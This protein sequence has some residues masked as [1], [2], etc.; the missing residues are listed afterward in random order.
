MT[1]EPT[2]SLQVQNPGLPVPPGVHLNCYGPFLAPAGAKSLRT[3]VPQ[4]DMSIVH[5][6]IMFGGRGAGVSQHTKPGQ[7]HLCFQGSIV[8]AWARTGQTTPLGLDFKD[9]PVQG[10]GFEVGPGTKYEW[11][12]LQIHYQ[13]LHSATKYDSSG[14]KLGFST[15]PP[16]RPLEVQLM[17]SWRLRIPPRSK[18]DECVACRV[19][20]GGTAVAWR[21]HAHRLA[22][23][24]YSEHF[25]R[26][27]EA[28][29]HLGL[30]SAQKPQ[31]F[32][33]ID[34]SRAI[35]TGDTL[36]LHCLYD[37]SDVRDRV[38]LL[39]VDERTHEMCNQ[40]LMATRD[41]SLN[42]NADRVVPDVGFA[43]AFSAATS[44]LA[45]GTA[46]RRLPQPAA[47][48][49]AA[50]AAAPPAGLDALRRIGVGQV[51]GLAVDAAARTLYVLHRAE[52]TFS[53]T[54]PIAGPAVLAYSFAG[55][56]I[57]ALAANTFVVPHGLSTDF[58]GA[59]WATDVALHQVLKLDPKAGGA[60]VQ[61]LGTKGQRGAGAGHF[62]KP[63]DVAVQPTTHEVFVADGYGNARV[64]VFSYAG[65]FLREF[66]AAGTGEGLFRVPHSLVFDKRGLLYVA[67]RENSRV[68]VFDPS[69]GQVKAQ[70]LSRVASAY[71]R[72][73]YSRH[74]SSISYDATLD[75]FAVCE[76]DAVVLRTPSGCSL[77][78]TDNLL[79]WPH[80]AVLL[81]AASAAARPSTPPNRTALAQ[82]G[83][84][85]ALFV[86]ELDGKRVKRYNAVD[87]PRARGEPASPYG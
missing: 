64:C 39:G 20:R 21:N 41:L 73:P 85:F 31:I 5:H 30:I 77:T 37:S 2:L 25:G 87:D 74:A 69:S 33:V 11:V 72:Y 83:A 66:G 4:V 42:C 19:T 86:A 50:A 45:T 78:Q 49:A 51:V 76:G 67:D 7:S 71:Q 18:M 34:G 24:V 59:L 16:L 48:A 9:T 75:L 38:T 22:R 14:V 40:Y 84:Q 23:D 6:M 17:A 47:A 53:S 36:L 29:P 68:Q 80:D 81:P 1:W 63:T 52:N 27:G 82:G 62:N 15:Q 28:K 8:Y 3:F 57:G 79:S 60:V 13:Q 65:A 12:A 10:D 43:S 26:H 58:S 44:A 70:W 54:A 56:L 35:E 32:R 61:T 55:E 46:A